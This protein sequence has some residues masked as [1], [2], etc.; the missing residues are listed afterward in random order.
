MK[1]DAR[2]FDGIARTLFA[3]IYPVIADQIIARTG[4]T[5]GICLD[6]G[7]GG[8]YLGAAIAR[9]TDLFV[10]LFDRSAEMLEIAGRMIVECGLQTRVARMQ[11][12]ISALPLPDGFANLV[13]SRGSV[14]FWQDLPGAFREIHRVLVPCGWAYIGGGFGTK[15]LKAGISR[16]MAAAKGNGEKFQ[17]LVRRN[18]SSATR[19]R[20]QAALETAGIE[21][22]SILHSEDIGL[23]IIIRKISSNDF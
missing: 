8:G 10:Y 11:G 4:M 6:I 5:Q 12:D 20:F 7:C 19:A 18:L 13:V 2:V 21:D 17:A 15:E 9:L 1:S 22:F 14:F 16:Q 23:W 3:P